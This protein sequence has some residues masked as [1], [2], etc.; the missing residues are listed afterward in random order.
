MSEKENH[1][2]AY[3]VAESCG[4]LGVFAYVIICER[5]WDDPGDVI[6]LLS[7]YSMEWNRD[8]ADQIVAC[9]FPV[10]AVGRTLLNIGEA[11]CCSEIKLVRKQFNDLK[12]FQNYAYDYAEKENCKQVLFFTWSCFDP[13]TNFQVP[14]FLRWRLSVMIN[15]PVKKLFKK[16]FKWE[17]V[18]KHTECGDL[19]IDN[20][21]A[22]NYMLS[23]WS[24]GRNYFFKKIFDLEKEK[25]KDVFS[26]PLSE[27]DWITLK[28]NTQIPV[29]D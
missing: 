29:L 13:V 19:K 20:I 18:T 10:R 3:W 22:V 26:E 27:K 4:K 25:I 5:F 6:R 7:F 14:C 15:K 12:E 24:D 28:E 9:N 1:R 16:H 21:P 8:K 11:C 23:D 17:A 2:T